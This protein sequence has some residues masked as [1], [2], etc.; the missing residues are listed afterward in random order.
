MNLWNHWRLRS[1]PSRR[2]LDA[3]TDVAP[4]VSTATQVLFRNT[5]FYWV[6]E[7]NEAP[8]WPEQVA[9]LPDVFP[10]GASVRTDLK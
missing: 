9:L 2:L 1:Y 10:A 8:G 5:W 7:A 6:G 4:W 3:R